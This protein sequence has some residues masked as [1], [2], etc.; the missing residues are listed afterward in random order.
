MGIQWIPASH[1]A[2]IAQNVRTITTIP[3]GSV[4]LDRTLGIDTN[5]LD[6]AGTR[7][8]ALYA[9][10]LIDALPLQEPRVS[11][12]RVTFGASESNGTVHPQIAYTILE[13][14]E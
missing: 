13:G 4:P 3:R 6:Q 9:A 11:V 1:T 10:A 12:D 7:G 2:E 14:A 5:V 8:Q